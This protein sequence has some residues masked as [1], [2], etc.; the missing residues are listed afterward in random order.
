[1]KKFKIEAINKR[2]FFL[3]LI[4]SFCVSLGAPTILLFFNLSSILYLLVAFLL[5]FAF[6]KRIEKI[7]SKTLLISLSEK[8][9]E[10]FDVQNRKILFRA[11]I[12]NL[13]RYRIRITFNNFPSFKILTTNGASFVFHC[14]DKGNIEF[15]NFIGD[16]R[17]IV[18]KNN[19]QGKII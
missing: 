14:A 17:E 5:G 13:N 9:L 18:E 19:I 1:M 12:E 4:L 15:Y 2:K 8:D 16:F 6:L 11:E 10:I 3:L 7:T